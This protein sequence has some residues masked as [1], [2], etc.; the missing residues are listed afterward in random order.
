MGGPQMDIQ[1]VSTTS[2]SQLE[3]N[4]D[5]KC[6]VNIKLDARDKQRTVE[7]SFLTAAEKKQFDQALESL[8]ASRFLPQNNLSEKAWKTV[9]TYDKTGE[10]LHPGMYYL[11]IRSSSFIKDKEVRVWGKITKTEL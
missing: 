7:V 8:L 10:V 4:I 3:V 11:V 1:R 5:Y 2:P 6:K 9:N